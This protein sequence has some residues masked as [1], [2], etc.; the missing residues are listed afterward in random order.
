MKILDDD[1]DD[2]DDVENAVSTFVSTW[3]MSN[4]SNN[5]DINIFQ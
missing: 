4:N 3:K 1:D 5:I 2:D